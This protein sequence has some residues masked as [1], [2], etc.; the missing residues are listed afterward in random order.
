MQLEA[1]ALLE[2]E[3]NKRPNKSKQKSNIPG[4]DL[5]MG[6]VLDQGDSNEAKMQAT[7]RR[8]AELALREVG[9]HF[10]PAIFD[11]L[12]ILWTIIFETLSAYFSKGT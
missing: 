8:G 4:D 1:L 9:V 5:P 12:P 2:L 10:G 3:S 6:T 11:Q 7:I